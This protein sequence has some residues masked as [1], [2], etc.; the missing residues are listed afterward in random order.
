[1]NPVFR[2]MARHDGRAGY[3]SAMPLSAISED[4]APRGWHDGGVAESGPAGGI[5]AGD[6]AIRTER[7]KN[8]GPR[9]AD[10]RAIGQH[11]RINLR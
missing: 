7:Q 3:P 4:A 5:A 6:P 10:A 2:M 8:F 1:M 9:I 11:A